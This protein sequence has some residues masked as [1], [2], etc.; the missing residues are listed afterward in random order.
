MESRPLHGDTAFS[1]IISP[2]TLTCLKYP[3]SVITD[4]RE[5][6]MRLKNNGFST[7]NSESAKRYSHFL[8]ENQIDQLKRNSQGESQ[9]FVL[10]SESS[11]MASPTDR[12]ASGMQSAIPS[13]IFRAKSSINPLNHTTPLHVSHF[14]KPANSSGICC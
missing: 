6:C 13:I 5:G 4:A 11:L 10:F 8:L 3:Y 2:C 12:S 9:T 14:V 1:N 7:V